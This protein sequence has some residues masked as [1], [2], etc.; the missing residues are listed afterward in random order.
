MRE[1]EQVTD[2]HITREKHKGNNDRSRKVLLQG[3]KKQQ[4]QRRG[5]KR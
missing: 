3:D 5:N 4:Q 1:R 2:V